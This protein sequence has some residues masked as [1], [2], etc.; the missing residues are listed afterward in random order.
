MVGK[1]KILSVEENLPSHFI[2]I[3]VNNRIVHF[4]FLNVHAGSLLFL[5]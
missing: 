2:A 1:Q 4:D 5:L 3:K